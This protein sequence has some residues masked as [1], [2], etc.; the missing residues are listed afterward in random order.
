[1]VFSIRTANGGL[2][3][4]NRHASDPAIIPELAAADKRGSGGLGGGAARGSLAAAAASLYCRAMSNLVWVE[5]DAT[6]PDHN[7]RELR[8]GLHR[9]VLLCAVIK[10]N[11]YGHGMLEMAGLLRSA[12]WL[13]VHSLE[14]GVTLREAGE[15][16]PILLLGH[17]ALEDLAEA[18]AR[19]LDLTV[20]NDETLAALAALHLPEPARGARQALGLHVKIETGTGRQGILPGELPGFLDRL[21]AVPGV[22]L[23]G[24]S[25]HFANIE[26][27]LNHAY[28][29]EQLERFREALQILKQRRLRP[30]CVHT[31]ATAAAI[32]FAKTHFTMVRAGI[33]VYGLWPSRETYLS[34]RLGRRR[35][36]DLRPVLSWKTRVSQL[37]ALPEGS[38]VGYGCTFR[39][40]RPTRVAVLPIGYSDGYDRALGNTAHVL[41]RGKRAP[42]IGRIC[43][44]LTMVDVTDIPQ[45]ALE[46]EVVLLGADGAERISAETLAAWAGTINYEMVSRISPLIERRVVGPT[47]ARRRP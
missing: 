38:Y 47:P 28:A 36:P 41:V 12:N 4:R 21:A 31:A 7:L 9:G 19:G 26:D 2:L 30:R 29:Q 27:T 17:V 11:A 44:N 34:A 45:V 35:V 10:A 24:V 39:T 13:A 46:D 1:M 16:R 37:K 5:L 20:Y 23:A 22:E 3:R 40:T 15:R 42:V 6:A 43:M 33:G 25:T 18:A 32:L 8:R 14:E